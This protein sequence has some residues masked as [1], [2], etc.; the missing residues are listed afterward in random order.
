MV[1]RKTYQKSGHRRIRN[2]TRDV[3]LLYVT[4]DDLT[5]ENWRILAVEWLETIKSGKALA[6][7]ML[8]R[9]LVD[10][11]IDQ[12]LSRDPAEFFRTGYVA[13]SFYSLCLSHINSKNDVSR[14]ISMLNRFID[15]TLERRFS[16][17]D[18]IGRKVIPHE[19]RN[20]IPF[21][22]PSRGI[23][24][25]LSESNKNILP[26]ALIREIR[27]LLCPSDAKNFSDWAW[28]H[29]AYEQGAGDWI[30][31]SK[32]CINHS[33][34]DCVWRTR[35]LRNR[36][37][38]ERI[39]ELWFP[40]RAVG[41]LTKLEL[42]LR[43]YQVRM[44]DSGEADT[45]VYIDGQWCDN[46]SPLAKGSKKS[47]Y[48]QGVFRKLVDSFKN[49]SMTGLYINTNKTADIN[50]E[51]SNRG[52]VI[53]WEHQNVLY[54]LSKL[55]DWQ[56]KYN[57]ISAPTPW[58]SLEA[59]HFGVVK[60][61]QVLKEMGECCFLFRDPTETPGDKPIPENGMNLLWYKLLAEFEE[62]CK[63]NN[64][65]GPGGVNL[66]FVDRETKVTTL[67]PLHSL[68]VSLITAFALEGGVSMPILSKCIAGHSRLVMTLY[69]TKTGVAYVSEQMTEAEKRISSQEHDSFARWL[70]DATYKELENNGVYSDPL[71]IEAVMAA[72]SSVANFSMDSKGICPKGATGCDSGGIYFNDDTGKI[73]YGPI[74]G[75]PEK[76][77]VR[78]RWFISG[79]AFLC[80]LVNHWNSVHFN[81]SEIGSSILNLEKQLGLLED[82]QYI[83]QATDGTFTRSS[84]LAIIQKALQSA[85]EQND[86]LANDSTATLR[87]IARC[88]SILASDS[89]TTGVQLVAVGKIDDVQISINECSKLQQVLTII[90]SSSIVPESD[91]SKVALKAGKS[92]DMM[93]ALNN[94]RPVF[95]RLDDEELLAAVRHLT[96]LLRAETGSIKN[97]L[98]FAE[99]TKQLAE[100]GILDSIDKFVHAIEQNSVQELPFGNHVREMILS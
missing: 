55:R 60:S 83:A 89:V 25:A 79:P 64:K 67:Y 33:D 44:L 14:I 90:S 50:K 4:N 62:R 41:L 57:P 9:F 22:A 82:E 7:N 85:I 45:Q 53:P 71:A 93:L 52:Y 8:K 2:S 68:R 66:S 78:C 23:N 65:L 6:M 38:T 28:A 15:F 30:K 13:P 75:Y 29:T 74:Q 5:M 35:E 40:G 63:R 88:R 80:G 24:R 61:A 31:V 51:Q 16:I 73:S 98:P 81:M 48:Q 3:Q 87:L 54:W 27:E 72:Q 59:K 37:K 91:F 18:D 95:F 99:G 49:V 34:P 42:P 92:F 12:N 21:D 26:Y 17:E 58:A 69:Y 19:F 1:S 46:E 56:S 36:R 43:T 47:P 96:E 97:A 100:L 20:P 76:N 70:K 84:E 10:Y 11:I 94:R 32:D 86:K 77:C 39:Y